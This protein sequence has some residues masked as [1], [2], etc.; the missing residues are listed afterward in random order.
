MRDPSQGTY[1]IIR[2]LHRFRTRLRLA[3]EVRILADVSL[4]A[5]AAGHMTQI[6]FIDRSLIKGFIFIALPRIVA[7]VRQLLVALVA[8]TKG[9]C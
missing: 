6:W 3:H 9:C 8:Y 5:G 7:F 2:S 4:Y 1:P